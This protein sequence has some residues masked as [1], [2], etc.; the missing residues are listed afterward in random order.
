MDFGKFRLADSEIRFPELSKPFRIQKFPVLYFWNPFGPA[1]NF[2]V[3]PSARWMKNPEIPKLEEIETTR[4]VPV[5][6]NGYM[7]GNYRLMAML[8]SELGS[9]F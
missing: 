7:C 4:I 3:P 5:D 6:L 1:L 8:Y 9:V 2:Y